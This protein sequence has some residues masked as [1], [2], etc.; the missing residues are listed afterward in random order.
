M[1]NDTLYCPTCEEK[2]T[3]MQG[4]PFIWEDQDLPLHAQDDRGAFVFD[5]Q[6]PQGARKQGY[7]MTCQSL[8]EI[9]ISLSLSAFILTA[10]WGIAVIILAIRKGK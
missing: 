3:V 9:I 5:K 8:P 6:I 10:T 7:V 2:L 1:A 4:A